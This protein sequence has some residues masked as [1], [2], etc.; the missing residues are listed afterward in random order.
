MNTRSTKRAAAPATPVVERKRGKNI[1]LILFETKFLCVF[2][3]SNEESEQKPNQ[4]DP[5]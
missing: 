2:F 4:I 5:K 1:F 3:Y